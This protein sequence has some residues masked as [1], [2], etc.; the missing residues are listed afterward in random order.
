MNTSYPKN[1]V[2]SRSDLCIMRTYT[3]SVL[4]IGTGI[5]ESGAD[6]L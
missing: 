6:G 3:N 4:Q 1:N 2:A 5:D